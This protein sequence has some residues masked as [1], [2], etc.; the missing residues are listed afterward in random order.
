[1]LIILMNRARNQYNLHRK[2]DYPTLI[3]TTLIIRSIIL[4]IFSL[5]LV[6]SLFD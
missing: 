6:L 5:V 2:A 4:K 1:M 3:N